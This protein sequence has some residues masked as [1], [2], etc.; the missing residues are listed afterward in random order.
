[1]DLDTA[2]TDSAGVA[3]VVCISC[4]E[5]KQKCD[6]ALPSC[7][8]CVKLVSPH[9]LRWPRMTDKSDR[10]LLRCRYPTS[11]SS[12]SPSESS[13]GSNGALTSCD[14]E[15]VQ[16]NGPLIQGLTS[17]T[18]ESQSHPGRV[19]SL[20]EDHKQQ[21]EEMVE[22]FFNTC[23]KWVPIVHQESFQERFNAP[24][25]DTSRGFA[26]LV[27]S[28]S[29]ITRPFMIE[30]KADPLR[31]SV[32]TALKRLFWDPESI[33][34]PTLSLIQ[35]GVILSNYEYGQGLCDAAYMTISVCLSM[36]QISILGKLPPS[37]Q[38][39]PLPLPGIWTQQQE[40]LRTWWS[41]LTHERFLKRFHKSA[42]AA[43]VFF[44]E[45]SV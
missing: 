3:S 25:R 31:V 29:L 13:N 6:K 4:K 18:G 28:M 10:L 15:V 5:R 21:F 27:L 30:G 32:Y 33:A 44:P 17:T 45:R 43:N 35:S 38:Q 34:R 41:I 1:M 9:P 26:A 37:H 7:S 8:R 22:I 11:P 19:S 40:S 2:H 23:H 14:H 20:I 39:P 42:V 36:A 24:Q 16:N 12:V